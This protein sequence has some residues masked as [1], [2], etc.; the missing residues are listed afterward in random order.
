MKQLLP[1]IYI[2]LLSLALSCTYKQTDITGSG[3]VITDK[4][5]PGTFTEIENNSIFNVSVI[6]ED[7]T[8]V[9]IETDDNIMPY[10][11]IFVDNDR[12][13]ISTKG[14]VQ[15]KNL[16][17][18]NIQVS[19]KDLN[20]FKNNGT[21][22]VQISQLDSL[23]ELTLVNNGTGNAKLDFNCISLS[24]RN[25]GTGNLRYYGDCTS[26]SL[27]NSAT[28]NV[29]IK[30]SFGEKIRVDN[31]GTGNIILAGQTSTFNLNNSGTGNIDATKLLAD[32]VEVYNNGTGDVTIFAGNK[33]TITST[34]TGDVY[35]RGNAPN[36]DIKNKGTG[37][38]IEE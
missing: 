13:I 15:L 22:N 6:R 12:L 16:S 37:N 10:L 2:L 23:M 9:M 8:A 20:L 35:Y 34:G 17:H 25:N 11:Q 26:L 36:K 31:N 33:L 18:K 29:H 32:A 30:G 19:V 7:T 4:R 3:N 1:L 14:N 28:G 24:I 38:I 5:Y 27:Y 21:G